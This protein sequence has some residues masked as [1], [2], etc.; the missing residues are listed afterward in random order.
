MNIQVFGTLVVVGALAG[1]EAAAKLLDTFPGWPF[2]WEL[3]VGWFGAFAR[4]RGLP[5]PVGW[6]FGPDLLAIAAGAVA[7]LVVFRIL[8][9]RF[10]IGFLAN[11][12][13][14]IAVVL[15]DCGWR[16]ETARRGSLLEMDV[17]SFDSELL[18][19]LML[20][21]FALL[22]FVSCHLG[23]CLAILRTRRCTEWRMSPDGS[24]SALQ[25]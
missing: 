3:S 9:F 13:F 14:G 21:G 24:S 4:A 1:A 11:L 5:S 16:S 7:A 12:S 2:A 8:R 18:V 23:F 17:T 19:P 6:L 20:L 22:G 25:R 10:G 15:A